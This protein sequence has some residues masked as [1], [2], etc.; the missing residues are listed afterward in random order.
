MKVFLSIIFVFLS[1]SVSNAADDFIYDD[2]GKR[3]PF[4]P[5]ISDTGTIVNYESDYLVTDLNLEGIMLGNGNGNIAIINGRIVKKGDVIGDFIIED[6][7][8]EKVVLYK[9]QKRFE[10]KLKKEE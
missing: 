9:G 6:I 2:Q 5:L 4:L 8:S 7:D 10:L 1:V 3:D